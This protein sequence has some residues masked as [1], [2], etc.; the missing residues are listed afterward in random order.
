MYAFGGKVAEAM[1][2]AAPIVAM[3]EEWRARLRGRVNL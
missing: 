1:K 2:P 3:T